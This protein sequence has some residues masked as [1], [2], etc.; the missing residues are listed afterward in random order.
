MAGAG[1]REVRG[2]VAVHPLAQPD[3]DPGGQARLR[4]GERGAERVARS[5]AQRLE[6]E[7][8]RRRD[9]VHA[10][11]VQAARRARAPQVLA[12]AVVLG[13]RAEA[14]GHLDRVAGPDRRGTPGSVAATRTGPGSTARAS[15]AD[16]VTLPRRADR[17][18]GRPP[19]PGLRREAAGRAARA[20]P[21]RTR[22][23]SRVAPTPAAV[24]A[25]D[26]R[27]PAEPLA[28]PADP[29]ARPS[30]HDEQRRHE[31]SEPPGARSRPTPPPTAAPTASQAL[32]GTRAGAALTARR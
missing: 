14:A 4:L 21:N 20:G 10:A 31:R 7:P 30:R 27:A 2:Q 19:R 8:R 32:R 18:H 11:R 3:Q 6:R 22:A 16:L 1:R 9:D 24:T 15:R 13:R 17:L 25:T 28:T 29:P 12:V 5:V 23:A 26:V